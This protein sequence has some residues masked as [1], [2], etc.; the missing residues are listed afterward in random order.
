MD[1]ATL[2]TAALSLLKPVISKAGVK[3]VEK[4]REHLP[5]GVGKVWDA[6]AAAFK[7]NPAA[8]TAVK[9]FVENPSD[10]DNEA[11]LR[12][13]IKK[14]ASADANFAAELE[15]LLKAAGDQTVANILITGSG[16]AAVGPGAVAAGAGGIAIGGNVEG[17]V[18]L[19]AQPKKDSDA[20]QQR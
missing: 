16:A 14:V 9:D 17:G 18:H 10:A 11:A 2:A 13:E 8:E 6:I 7:G 3:L 19:G 5:D 15:K 12:K 1:P 4:V 20:D